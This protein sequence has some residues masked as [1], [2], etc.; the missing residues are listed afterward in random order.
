MMK[1]IKTLAC[2]FASVNLAL[3]P[4]ISGEVYP[5]GVY[6]KHGALI[7]EHIAIN[8]DST[9]KLQGTC[10]SSK[11]CTI[12]IDGEGIFTSN[13]DQIKSDSIIGWTISNATNSGGILF[14]TRNEDYRFLIKYFDDLGN[15]NVSEIGF[16]NFKSAQSFL[17]SLELLSGL[18]LNH[19][20]AGI[21]TH[22]L[23]IGKDSFSGTDTD[24]ISELN[25]NL[26]GRDIKRNTILGSTVGAAAGAG[27]GEIIGG[28]ALTVATGTLA[29]GI[30]GGFIGNSLGK[31]SGNLNLK[32]NVVSE[33][34]S[35]PA[36]SAAFYDASY[37]HREKCKDP[38]TFRSH[39]HH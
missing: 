14:L 13:G 18:S 27:V 7:N 21:T 29:G 32:R 15:R 33:F 8:N 20:Q 5:R 24:Q 17:N 19:D 16:Y 2:L 11:L 39:H 10:N 9:V 25:K 3:A 12:A 34:R 23:A 4:A 36:D 37:E 35:K 28:P 22:C 1:K 6:K 31:N 38:I 30:V 26:Y